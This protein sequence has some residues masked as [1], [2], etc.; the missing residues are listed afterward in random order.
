VEKHEVKGSHGNPRRVWE[1]SIK[2]DLRETGWF[3]TDWMHLAKDTG[4]TRAF[5]NSVITL[6]VA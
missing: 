3:A 1:N 6:L 2:M 5:V 4:K